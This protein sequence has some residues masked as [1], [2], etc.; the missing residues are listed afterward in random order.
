MNINTKY[1]YYYM[2]P[3]SDALIGALTSALEN[4]LTSRVEGH[5]RVEIVHLEYVEDTTDLYVVFRATGRRECV[6]C[7]ASELVAAI[8]YD[9]EQAWK[10]ASTGSLEQEIEFHGFLSDVPA[11]LDV[12]IDPDT[13]ETVVSV[14]R[15]KASDNSKSISSAPA[16]ANASFLIGGFAISVS[17]L[18]AV[19]LGM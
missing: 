19:A 15:K 4:I 2:L 6:E 7:K 10:T 9:Y 14:N 18:M 1:Y 13:V 5:Q 3:I 8:E 11:L 17:L 12:K 16:L